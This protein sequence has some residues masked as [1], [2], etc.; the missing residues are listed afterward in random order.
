MIFPKLFN[1]GN[2]KSISVDEGKLVMEGTY[3]KEEF[4]GGSG[5]PEGGY[6]GQVI[7]KDQGEA[8]WLWPLPPGDAN[9]FLKK[10]S[11]GNTY[12][13]RAIKEVPAEGTTGQVLT[14]TSDGYGWA[15]PINNSRPTIKLYVILDNNIEQAG[16]H[17]YDNKDIWFDSFGSDISDYI[18]DAGTGSN[19]NKNWLDCII[20]LSEDDSTKPIAKGLIR[21]TNFANTQLKW[22]FTG[23]GTRTGNV[24]GNYYANKIITI[25]SLNCEKNFLILLTFFFSCITFL[26]LYNLWS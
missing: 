1:H 17:N 13:F 22:E 16:L 18:V 23:T 26:F 7:M 4:E 8:K 3:G 10:T 12:A 5:L 2:L 15:A 14:K 6:D 20:V 11:E 25:K 24:G 21:F 9:T 19:S